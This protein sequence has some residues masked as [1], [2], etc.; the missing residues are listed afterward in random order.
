MRKKTVLELV[1]EMN[2]ICSNPQVAS[3]DD[4]QDAR[5]QLALTCLQQTAEELSI[6]F[7][8]I[9]QLRKTRMVADRSFGYDAV[10]N[11]YDLNVLT[12]NMFSR[13]TTTYLYDM[14]DKKI[15]PELVS[16]D[17]IKSEIAND[18]FFNRFLRC[19]DLIIFQPEMKENAIIEF[20]YQMGNIAYEMVGNEK[21]FTDNFNNDAYYS[22]LDDKLLVR[23]AASRYRIATSYDNSREEQ[24]FQTYLEMVKASHS[25]MGIISGYNDAYGFKG[26]IDILGIPM[27]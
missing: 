13:F 3:I 15:I 9:D 12:D 27:F 25:P 6:S 10:L 22:V 17:K 16:D 24:I 5:S 23:G 20:Y 4:M 1:N 14:T 7:D 8:W 21:V 19:G 26:A 2:G 18:A 11:G